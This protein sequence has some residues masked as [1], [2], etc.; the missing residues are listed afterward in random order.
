ML[1]NSDYALLAAYGTTRKTIEDTEAGLIN[2]DLDD[3]QA[4]LSLLN[5]EIRKKGLQDKVNGNGAV[6]L[7][8]VSQ[9]A[10]MSANDLTQQGATWATLA[11]ELAPIQWDWPNWLA[12]GFQTIV[13]GVTGE[14][15]SNLIL[16][17]A[18]CYLTGVN[19]PDG[20]PF[21]NEPGEILW[22]ETESAQALNL[23][24]ARAWGLPVDRIR[25]PLNN[26][27][28]NVSLDNPEHQAS[29]RAVANNP[30]VKLVILDSL[31]A[32]TRKDA[33]SSNQMLQVMGF[34]AE[35]ARDTNKPVLTTHHLRKKGMLDTDVVN[36]DRL[37]DSS[38][39][40]QLARIIWAIDS[41]DPEYPDKKRLYVI[42][43]NLSKFPNPIGFEITETGL[44]FGNAPELPRK[45]TQLDRA[46][47]LLKTLLAKEPQKYWV[48]E[49][50]ARSAAISVDTMRRAKEKLGVNAV[51]VGNSW[52]WS[53]P[54]REDL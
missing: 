48:V 8:Q 40:A 34:V 52:V 16:H 9:V 45:E 11:A 32:G 3:L 25:T 44:K 23:E 37:R 31:S 5:D 26:P 13:A 27:L 46:M 29:I 28:D 36:L 41:P 53:L 38:A 51:K 42:K 18:L 24:R 17:I 7:S 2:K 49:E 15:K 20:T 4:Q 33:K 30:K 10:P 6:A 43:S 21:N 14:G 47:D 50:E 12:K 1:S 19:W 35:L 22:C 39:I 54:V